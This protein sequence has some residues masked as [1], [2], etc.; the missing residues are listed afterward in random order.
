V[1]LWF[2]YDLFC[3]V[4]MWFVLNLLNQKSLRGIYRVA[5]T[6]RDEE[7]IWKGYGGLPVADF[8]KCFEH[9]VRF[10]PD[11]IA[12]GKNLWECYQASDLDT[13]EKLSRT[14]SECFPY[15]REVCEA[16]IERKKNKRPEETLRR[17]AGKGLRDF[18]QIFR[19]VIKEE[20]V[21]GFGDLQ[22]KAMFEKIRTTAAHPSCPERN[23]S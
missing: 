11:D 6:T 8:P 12:L 1:F 13:L 9:R 18:N 22:V 17:I 14:E 10:K 5:P 19:E 16:E 23:L 4:N 21:Y 7:D 20:G 3:Q 15:H 2:K